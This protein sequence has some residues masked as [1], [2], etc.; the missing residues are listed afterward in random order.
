MG[1]PIAAKLREIRAREGLTTA[2]LARQIGVDSSYLHLVFR[3]ERDIGR[4]MLD[5]AI[6][7][8]PEV[9]D[10]Y[11]QALTIRRDLMARRS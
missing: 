3:G 7:A 9:A 5:G 6:V 8:Y 11:A 4:K 1:D 2:A 10:V